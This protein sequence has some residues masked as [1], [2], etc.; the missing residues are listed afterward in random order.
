MRPI[1][2]VAVLLISL[3][4]SSDEK[5]ILKESTSIGVVSE[6]VYVADFY[7]ELSE[8]NTAATATKADRRGKKRVNPSD[9]QLATWYEDQRANRT[10]VNFVENKDTFLIYLSKTDIKLLKQFLMYM[11]RAGG[12]GWQS[13][14]LDGKDVT[15]DSSWVLPTKVQVWKN[16][17]YAIDK[18]GKV[19]QIVHFEN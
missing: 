17:R 11:E 6:S 3:G 2:I 16:R 18:N 5:D 19:R 12:I 8:V 1:V 10:S 15:I 7:D 14:R 9:T 4:C 13:K